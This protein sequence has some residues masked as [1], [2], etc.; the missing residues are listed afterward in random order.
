MKLHHALNACALPLLLA[1]PFFA[2]A[3]A[4]DPA[5]LQEL[6][7]DRDDAQYEGISV[8]QL[9]DMDV[10]RDGQV[11]GEVEEVLGDANGEIVALVIEYG[12]D[13]IG[14]GDREVIVPVEEFQVSAQDNV[15]ETV[16]SDEELDGMVAWD[17]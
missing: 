6:D 9:E 7:D 14:I 2:A 1:V 15:L 10:V 13:A 12:G 17:D 8:D 16:L 4:L 3:Q 5:T 11:I